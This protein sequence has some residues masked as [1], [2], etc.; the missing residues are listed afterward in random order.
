[1]L[2]LVHVI[3]IRPFYTMKKSKR[4][5]SQL[6]GARTLCSCYDRITTGPRGRWRCWIILQS[7]KRKISMNRICIP[8]AARIRVGHWIKEQQFFDFVGIKQSL[9]AIIYSVTAPKRLAHDFQLDRDFNY[10]HVIETVFLSL[11]PI[12]GYSLYLGRLAI[13]VRCSQG[14]ST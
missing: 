10:R 11:S 1:M 14:C 6:C 3:N 7:M 9:R 4:K 13:A 2:V 8:R 5:A 12:T